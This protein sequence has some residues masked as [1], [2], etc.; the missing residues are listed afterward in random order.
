LII[1]RADSADAD[2][3]A[4]AHIQAWEETYRGLIPDAAFALHSLDTR[5][6]QWRATLGNP[7]VLVH[8]AERDG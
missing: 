7:A 3:I 4:R 5:I 1:R 8:V 2:Q 6:A